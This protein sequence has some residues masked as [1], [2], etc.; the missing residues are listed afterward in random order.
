MEQNKKW[1]IVKQGLRDSNAEELLQ[2][3]FYLFKVEGSIKWGKQCLKWNY[4]FVDG[5][6]IKKLLQKLP[7]K[8]ESSFLLYCIKISGRLL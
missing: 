1:G 7:K 8:R 2:G 6:Y 5:P 3:F 4:P